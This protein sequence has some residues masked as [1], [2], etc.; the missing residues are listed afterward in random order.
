MNKKTLFTAFLALGLALTGCGKTGDS[1]SSSSSSGLVRIEGNGTDWV[2]SIKAL[3]D[4]AYEAIGDENNTIAL[5]FVNTKYYYAEFDHLDYRENNNYEISATTIIAFDSEEETIE[6]SK[7]S[8]FLNDYR[9]HYSDLGFT[10]DMSSYSKNGTY[11]AS[12][13]IRGNKYQFVQFG[14]RIMGQ[15]DEYTARYGIYISVGVQQYVSAGGYTGTNL[16]A[17]PTEGLEE[18]LGTDILHPTYEN[19]ANISYFGGWNVFPGTDKQ[20]NDILL[21]IYVINCMGATETDYNNYIKALK[22]AG[23]EMLT[24]AETNEVYGA[25]DYISGVLIQF[26]YSTQTGYQGIVIFAYL[27]SEP[28]VKTEGL[29]SFASALPNY[30]EEGKTFEY[31]Y[32]TTTESEP[33]VGEYKIHT[34]LISGVSENACDIYKTILETNGFT[35]AKR[36]EKTQSGQEYTYYNAQSADGNTFLQFTDGEYPRIGHCLVIALFDFGF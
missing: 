23:L 27:A 25:Y 32:Q 9:T 18:L 14:R 35:V 31:Y 36:T 24:D 26:A 5:P 33:T 10:V 13:A 4:Q 22:D 12:K 17:W 30:V 2:D 6:S 15:I 29:P 34:I 19:E 28:F 11:M 1:S 7:L 21:D 8:S 20:G 3:L 16:P